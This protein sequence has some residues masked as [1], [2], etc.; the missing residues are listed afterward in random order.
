ML[1]LLLQG[2][3]VL[4]MLAREGIR[5]LRRAYRSGYAMVPGDARPGSVIDAPRQ[6]SLVITRDPVLLPSLAGSVARVSS[7]TGIHAR[8]RDAGLIWAAEHAVVDEVLPFWTGLGPAG[9]DVV[10]VIRD[11]GNAQPD[12]VLAAP[13]RLDRSTL[14]AV[15][16][17][18]PWRTALVIRIR[19]AVPSC[20]RRPARPAAR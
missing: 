5:R 12:R 19:K 16:A 13:A 11:A 10:D 8:A 7:V 2:V 6:A 15:I 20:P 1:G 3:S 4:V 18:D 14:G 9:E 17:A